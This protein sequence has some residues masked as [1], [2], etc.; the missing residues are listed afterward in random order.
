MGLVGLVICDML[1]YKPK[2]IY[3]RMVGKVNHYIRSVN[4]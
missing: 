2:L 4:V 3:I 1:L